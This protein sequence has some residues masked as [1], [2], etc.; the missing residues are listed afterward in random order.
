MNTDKKNIP[1]WYALYT[2]PRFEKKVDELLSEKGLESYLPLQMV[3]RQWS[4]RKE[5]VKEPLFSC[6]VF[7]KLPLRQSVLAVQT[8]GVI[9]MVSFTGN[10]SPIPGEEIEA[11]K[12]ILK[13]ERPFKMA[14]YLQ[15][16]QFVEVV[17]GPLTGVCGRLLE[18]RGRG[19]LLVGIEQIKQAISVEIEGC[20]VKP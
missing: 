10:P 6:Y 14:Q 19:K 20:E 1:R 9:R 16:G 5:K 11:I 4:D 7:V 13:S 12:A 18:H 3:L 8:H 2:R 17:H 15:E